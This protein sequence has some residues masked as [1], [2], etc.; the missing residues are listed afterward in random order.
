MRERSETS[1]GG[2]VFRRVDTSADG[3]VEVAIGEQRDRLTKERTIRL[4]KGHPDRDET[5]QQAALRE[6]EEEFG[7]R[8]RI[9]GPLGTSRYVY[10]EKSVAVC[11]HV[12]FFLMEWLPGESLPIDGEMQRVFW[13]SLDEAESRLTFD[14]EKQA[15][16]WARE[17]LAAGV[18]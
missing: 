5:L 11:K 8:T 3:A 10:Q 2:V 14:N 13:C 17:Q 7:L 9:V 16:G 15:I 4:A 12:H 6:V 1:A 18:G